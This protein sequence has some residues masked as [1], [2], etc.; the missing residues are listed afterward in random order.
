MPH[1]ILELILWILL[2]FFVG[3]IIGCILRKL[4]A[5]QEMPASPGLEGPARPE[6]QATKVA[7]EPEAAALPVTGKPSRPKGIAAAREGVPD[8][9][10]RISGIGPKNEKTL[11]S[12]GFFHFD[13]IAAWTPEEIQWVDEDLKFN[14]RIIREKWVHQAALLA[15]G[16]EEEFRSLYGSGGVKDGNGT[17]K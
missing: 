16:K 6:P 1:L 10:Q 9:L 15:E 4:F 7:D 12:L 17:P 14:G 3:C 8:N 11:H 5:R 2:A 13:Q